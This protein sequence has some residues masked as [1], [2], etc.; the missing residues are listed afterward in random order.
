VNGNFLDFGKFEE[1]IEIHGFLEWFK[2]L[3]LKVFLVVW[4]WFRDIG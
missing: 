3:T 1:M 2:R 4:F